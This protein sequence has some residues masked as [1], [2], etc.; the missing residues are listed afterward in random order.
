M[1]LNESGHGL[2]QINTDKR[3]INGNLEI[4][5]SMN[6]GIEEPKKVKSKIN[7]SIP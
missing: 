6:S 4:K 1:I 7:S 2:T 3:I 5:G